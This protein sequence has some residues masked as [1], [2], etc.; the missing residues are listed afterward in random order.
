MM[1]GS[2][3]MGVAPGFLLGEV[4]DE[5]TQGDRNPGHEEQRAPAMSQGSLS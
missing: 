3:G 4:V 5:V 1:T 2:L